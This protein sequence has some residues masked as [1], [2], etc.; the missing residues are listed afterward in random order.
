MKKIV[1]FLLVSFST[2]T[3]VAQKAVTFKVAYKPNKVYVQNI[4]QNAKTEI[5]Y[6]ASDDILEMLQAQGVTNPTVTENKSTTKCV[7]T[8]GK[9]TG[10]EI[11][12]N[13]KVSLDSGTEQKIIPDNTMIYGKVKQDGM[14][15]FDSIQAPGMD[16]AIKEIFMKTMQ[17]TVS[18]IVVPEKKVKV[19]E[20]FTI[21]LPLSIPIGAESMTIND[22]ATYKLL[23]VEGVKAYF[24]VSHTYTINS[25][26]SGQKIQGTGFGTGKTTHDLSN[27][28]VLQQDLKMKLEMGFD[29][30]GI[31]MVIKSDS[32]LSLNC[33]ISANK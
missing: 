16:V 5:T 13:M 4:S 22:V 21:T 32:D 17:A 29:T 31:T 10:T 25:E 24:D 11:P 26:V 3:V 1:L 12:L 8:T 7:V 15:V 23:K 9:L 27:D 6:K 30:N 14:P 2:L 20:T 18:Q 28:F 33:L 19:G